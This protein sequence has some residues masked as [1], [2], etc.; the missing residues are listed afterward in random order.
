MIDIFFQVVWVK[1]NG[2]STHNTSDTNCVG[3]P[4]ISVLQFSVDTN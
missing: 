3:F 1:E 4:H 2:F